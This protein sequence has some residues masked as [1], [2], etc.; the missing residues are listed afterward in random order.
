MRPIPVRT[1]IHQPIPIGRATAQIPALNAHLGGHRRPDPDPGSGDLAFELDTQRDH[2]LLM[3]LS[4]EIDP[5]AHLRHPQLHPVVLEQRRHQTELGT[6]ERPLILPATIASNARSG[7]AIA[8]TSAAACGR[9][10][11][12][13][14][15]LS[16]TSKN[17]ATTRPN[18]PTSASA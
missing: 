4:L 6:I 5:T 2:Q 13:N 16:P 18:P 9:R 12:G 3:T 17:S 1:R 11:R 15:R 14:T 10:A 8:L 7:S